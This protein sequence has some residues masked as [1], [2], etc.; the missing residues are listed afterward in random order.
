MYFRLLCL[1][2]YSSL[3][4]NIV[5]YYITSHSHK[6]N[7]TLLYIFE[8]SFVTFSGLC[9]SGNLSIYSNL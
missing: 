9:F 7:Q 3:Q 5:H 2:L 1:I 4:G 8:S 6:L